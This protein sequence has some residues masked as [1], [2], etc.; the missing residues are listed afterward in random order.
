[1]SQ[2]QNKYKND[3]KQSIII[4]KILSF[5]HISIRDFLLF[6]TLNPQMIILKIWTLIVTKDFLWFQCHSIKRIH[7]NRNHN[8]W[9]SPVSKIVNLCYVSDLPLTSSYACSW[10]S[11]STSVGWP[12]NS[13]LPS[14]QTWDIYV[15]PYSTMHII[16]QFY[17]FLASHYLNLLHRGGK[18][19]HYL[20]WSLSLVALIN[21]YL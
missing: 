17:Y 13:I 14:S 15:I 18:L 16:T 21:Y 7:Q 5:I 20:L 8:R 4:Q 6:T 1:M 12:V 19:Y 11:L 9:R 2:K 3:R 10:S